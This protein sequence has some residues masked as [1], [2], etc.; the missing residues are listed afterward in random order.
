MGELVL[1]RHGQTEW[2]RTRRHT[3]L[4][5]VPLT[6]EGERQAE[7]LRPLL[8][9]RTIGRVITSPLGRAVRTAGLAGLTGARVDPDLGEWD[10]GGYEGI[11]T[12]EIREERPGWDLWRD[13]VVPGGADHPGERVEE[14]AARVDR[15]LASS[16]EGVGDPGSDDVVLVAHGH[17]LRVLTARWLGLDGRAGALFSLGTGAV[18]TLGREH[19]RPVIT[20]WN[21]MP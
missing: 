2:S 4:T 20:S 12:A 6:E 19:D 3:G 1:V 11:T 9:R 8:A 5:D 13:G 16:A 14:V 15:V 7:A 17:V 18:C 10:Y 21:L